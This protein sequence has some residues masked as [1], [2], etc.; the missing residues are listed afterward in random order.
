MATATTPSAPL[1]SVSR[2]ELTDRAEMQT[3]MRQILPGGLYSFQVLGFDPQFAKPKAGKEV[4]VN[5]NPRIVLFD[6]PAPLDK[7][8]YKKRVFEYLNQNAW[9]HEDF[10]HAL[11]LELTVLP[12]GNLTLP[13]EFLA[14]P[15]KEFD[16]LNT[17]TWA[18]FGPMEKATGQFNLIVSGVG[19]K[20]EQNKIES[21]V[22]KVPGC[23]VKHNTGINRP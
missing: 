17:E 22:C 1:M 15:G 2:Q 14:A 21:F 13:G 6:L 9:Y 10:A 19:T 18:Y 16:S 20:Y 23:T 5:L 4:S 12:N 8:N 3:L 11:G 7:L